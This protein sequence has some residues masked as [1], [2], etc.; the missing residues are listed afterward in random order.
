LSAS[1]RSIFAFP[2]TKIG[3]EVF[4]L[5]SVTE[6][7]P[8]TLQTPNKVV[9]STSQEVTKTVEGQKFFFQLDNRQQMAEYYNRKDTQ[10]NT[11]YFLFTN[12]D[13]ADDGSDEVRIEDPSTD[14]PTN[15]MLFSGSVVYPKDENGTFE[16]SLKSIFIGRSKISTA[17]DQSGVLL[18]TTKV[19]GDFMDR[20]ACLYYPS[21]DRVLSLDQTF[22]DLSNLRD[23]EIQNL[24]DALALKGDTWHKP[25]TC[26]IGA[27][28]AEVKEPVAQQAPV[29]QAP[30][31][32]APVQQAPVQQAPVQ[33][34]PVQ[35]AP[36]QKAPVQ[37]APVQKAPVQQAP[38]QKAPVQQAP[39]QKAPVQKAPVQQA[40]ADKTTADMKARLDMLSSNEDDFAAFMTQQAEQSASPQTTVNIPV[41]TDPLAEAAKLVSEMKQH[42]A[43]DLINFDEDED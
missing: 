18:D 34:A 20:F 4:K 7:T 2:D 16:I 10:A 31:Q 38:V 25:L 1:Y 42:N 8:Q 36:V 9:V 30:V 29:Q 21:G 40:P 17:T 5:E 13:F 26:E 12:A 11:C 14:L 22:E 39:V 24:Y 6:T 43:A 35:Q 37:Q 23:T 41:T 27:P 28:K 3:M 15:K 19:F 32:K 33:K